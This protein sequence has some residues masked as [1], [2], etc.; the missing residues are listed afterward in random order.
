MI[1]SKRFDVVAVDMIGPFNPTERGNR[2]TLVLVD[3][4]TRWPEAVPLQDATSHSIAHGILSLTVGRWGLPRRLLSDQ[5]SNFISAAIQTVYK[6]VGIEKVSTTPFWA[7][8]NG[9]RS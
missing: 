8:C 9:L 7:R 5:G 6:Y 4:L 2:W 1:P 3:Y